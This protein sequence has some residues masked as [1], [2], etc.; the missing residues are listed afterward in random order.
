MSKQWWKG[1]QEAAAAQGTGFPV[2]NSSSSGNE[3]NRLEVSTLGPALAEDVFAPTSVAGLQRQTPPVEF[4]PTEMGSGMLPL[5]DRK[6]SGGRA[7]A[8]SAGDDASFSSSGLLAM[9]P[10]DIM[11][12]PE[13]EEAAIRFANGD[14][15][16]AQSALVSALNG[17]ALVPDVAQAWVMALLYFYRSTGQAD[18][19]DQVSL[20]YADRLDG[21]Q[22]RWLDIRQVQPLA[23]QAGGTGALSPTS[24]GKAMWT[25]PVEL[26]A[27]G[28]EELRMTLSSAAP[29]WH[30]D[31]TA[32]HDIADSALPFLAG[33]FGS[34]CAETVGLRFSGADRLAKALRDLTPSGSRGV[35]DTAWTV[36]L[37][38]L[39]VMQMQD[40]F[41][42]AALDFCITFEV[43][44]PEWSPA[45][46]AYA[47]ADQ[48]AEGLQSSA[49]AS[50]TMPLGLN[51]ASGEALR[52]SGDV[53]GEAGSATDLL[54]R[55]HAPGAHLL[56]S[57]RGLVRVDFSAAGSILNWAATCHSQGCQ[58]QFR[59]VNRLVAAFFN[60]IGITEY[61]RV[62]LLT[63]E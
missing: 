28:M 8:A 3:P 31:W 23:N 63:I 39:R 51:G 61:A 33:L 53:V 18:A 41:E 13:L 60:V 12:D 27:S 58:V 30:L 2:A 29:P 48:N 15:A 36:R 47:D 10:D 26:T 14:D 17:E 43:P 25:S 57:C 20:D 55:D 42:L 46:C 38:A 49:P 50:S 5:Q 21:M 44:P 40:E 45:R 35:D 52:L 37:D 22:P 62:T 7:I 54:G 24:F 59:D 11:T 6:A 34:L 4:A 16:G 1:K 56:V 19:F 9:G 32:L